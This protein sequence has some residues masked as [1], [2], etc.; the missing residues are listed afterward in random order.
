[1]W[2]FLDRGIQAKGPGCSG[3]FILDAQHLNPLPGSGGVPQILKLVPPPFKDS[4]ILAFPTSLSA[5]NPAAAA[6]HRPESDLTSSRCV[7][8]T[9]VT[10]GSLCV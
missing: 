4:Q 8:P 2:V 1:M 10:G 3:H 9:L 7:R 5:G 6:T